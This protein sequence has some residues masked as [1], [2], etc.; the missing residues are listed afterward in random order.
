[1]SQSVPYPES[2]TR[3]SDNNLED[4]KRR[5]RVEVGQ[6]RVGY[7]EKWVPTFSRKLQPSSAKPN[8]ITSTCLLV[9]MEISSYALLLWARGHIDNRSETIR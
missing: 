1:M 8:N 6:R 5:D 3:S 9:T 2:G 4:V 7:A